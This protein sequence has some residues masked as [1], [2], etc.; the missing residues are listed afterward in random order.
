MTRTR[1]R[2]SEET[3]APAKRAKIAE[4]EEKQVLVDDEDDTTTVAA[5]VDNAVENVKG[6]DTPTLSTESVPEAQLDSSEVGGDKEEVSNDTDAKNDVDAKTADEKTN[7]ENIES[8]NQSVGSFTT[9]IDIPEAPG[10]NFISLLIGPQGATMQG[11][12]NDSG[13][14]IQIRGRGSRKDGSLDNAEDPLHVLIKGSTQTSIDTASKLVKDLL[15]NREKAETLRDAQTNRKKYEKTIEVPVPLRFVG[16]VIGRGGDTIRSIRQK[17]TA[18]VH[19]VAQEDMPENSQHRDVICKGD[20]ESV[21]I[22]RNLIEALI[23]ERL[24]E[25]KNEPKEQPLDEHH[26]AHREFNLPHQRAGAVIGRRGVTIRGIQQRTR[27]NVKIPS[28]PDPTLTSSS[29]EK[30]RRVTVSGPSEECVE[31][32]IDEM[33]ALINHDD[34]NRG[35]GRGGAPRDGPPTATVT[36]PNNKVGVVIGK[37]GQ[38]IR[39]LIQVTGAFVKVPSD[40]DVGSSPPTRTIQLTGTPQQCQDVTQKIL[41]L[42]SDDRETRSRLQEQLGFETGGGRRSN[43]Q[44]QGGYYGQPSGQFQGYYGQQQQYGNRGGNYGQQ[45]GGHYGGGYGGQP[46]YQQQQGY[47]RFQTHPQHAAYNRQAAYG[48]QQPYGQQ[49][50]VG[51]QS[52]YGQ[53]QPQQSNQ[54]QAAYGQQQSYGYNTTGTASNS[55][56]KTKA[57]EHKAAW[58][59]YYAQQ[60]A[61]QQQA[62]RGQP[63]HQQQVQP[64]QQTQAVDA[65]AHKAAWDAY[66]AQ[67]A[68]QQG[69]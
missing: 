48:H 13:A 24:E 61:L 34:M 15:F 62:G 65:A 16:L 50:A 46:Q 23:A 2:K 7:D 45:Q 49:G 67:Q 32:A 26:T 66:Y 21:N 64:Q 43:M 55:D 19:V 36:V 33:T 27:T 59:R 39:K 5:E 69:R 60:A 44:Q 4:S 28:E 29:G 51:S 17:S 35:G 41:I 8:A 37:G 31:A 53:Q 40:P 56:A 47:N 54:A 22:A 68:Q 52:P 12:E 63:Q 3:D 9:R 38:M 20:E 18:Y 11:M 58:D 10:I 6:E 57:E 30:F 42:C 1:K 14:V 25:E